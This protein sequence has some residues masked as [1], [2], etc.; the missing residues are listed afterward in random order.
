MRCAGAAELSEM[1]MRTGHQAGRW[2]AI[3]DQ[4]TK[5]HVTREMTAR[6]DWVQSRDELRKC[7]QQVWTTLRSSTVK[8]SRE[9]GVSWRAV[10]LSTE[11]GMI[12]QRGKAC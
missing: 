7:R 3:L 12:P 4:M 1:R 6:M 10:S 5:W 11:M 8:T 9:I 2:E